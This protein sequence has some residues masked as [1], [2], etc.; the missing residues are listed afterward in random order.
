MR[1]DILGNDLEY[2]WGAPEAPSHRRWLLEAYGDRLSERQQKV[3]QLVDIDGWSVAKVARLLGRSKS[4]IRDALREA[5][6][7]LRR[8][9]WCPPVT[10]PE[11]RMLAEKLALA[12]YGVLKVPQQAP[13]PEKRVGD[14]RKTCPTCG[15]PVE[16][17]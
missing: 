7:L 14:G 17:T 16:V 10:T 15:H 3:F 13:V 12:G 1:V 6:H 11:V 9:G 2:G 8:Y 5:R 4:R